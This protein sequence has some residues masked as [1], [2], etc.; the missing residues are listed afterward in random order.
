MAMC[1]V[2]KLL[3]GIA[4]IVDGNVVR[5]PM[6]NYHEGHYTVWSRDVGYPHL[7]PALKRMYSSHTQ[8]PEPAAVLE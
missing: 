4:D 7:Y 8:I 5:I 1:S 2:P 3:G 6:R